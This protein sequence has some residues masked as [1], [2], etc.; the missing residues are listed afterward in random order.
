MRAVLMGILVACSLCASA[1]AQV[2]LTA[3]REQALKAGDS[4][5]ECAGCPEMVVIPA[6]EFLMGSPENERDRDD[7]E[8]PQHRVTISKRFALGKFELTVD[9]FAAFADET[10][11]DTGDVCDLWQ[12]GKFDQQKGYNWR[13]PNFSQTGAHPAVANLV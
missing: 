2:P 9:E 6:G 11:Y 1:P 4:F 7:S 5:R 13:K 8:G 10:R 12:D 3:A